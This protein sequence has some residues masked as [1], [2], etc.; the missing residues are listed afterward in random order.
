MWTERWENKGA[1][2]SADDMLYIF[3]EKKGNVGLVNPTPEKFDLISSFKMTKGEGPFW[4]HPVI[5]DGKL[6]L[7]HGEVLMVHDIKQK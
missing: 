5:R 7:R 3:D 6:Y 1:V 4:A 2:I